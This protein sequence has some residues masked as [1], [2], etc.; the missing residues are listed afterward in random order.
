MGLFS[1]NFDRPGPGVAKDEPRK[2]GAARF[3]EILL[4]DF[5]DLIKLSL[6][7]SLCALPSVATFIIG[8]LPFM[9]GTNTLVLVFLLP[10]VIL[11]YPIG[12]AVVACYFNISRF[13]RDDPS[14]LWFDFKRKFKE[15]VKQAAPAGIICTTFIYMQVLVWFQM[16]YQ[17]AEGTYTGGL[18]ML[19]LAIMSLLMFSMIVPYIFLHYAYIDLGALRILK[20]SL[21]MAFAYIP[22]SFM[23]ALLGG[24][25]WILIAIT[26]PSSLVI[27]PLVPLILISLSMMLTLTWIWPKFNAYFDI[28]ETL[29]KRKE[30]KNEQ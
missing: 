27:A 14:Y 22:R 9:F 17:L 28:E 11:A 13:M 29:K 2:K 8:S 10:S 5:A 15:N 7:F 1:R 30:E 6:L 24:I 20:N 12:G 19:L 25:I 18:F 26:L 21:L 23:G 3:F 4:R 16:Y